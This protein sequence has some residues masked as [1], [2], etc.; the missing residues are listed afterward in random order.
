[1]ENLGPCAFESEPGYINAFLRGMLFAL[2]TALVPKDDRWYNRLHEETSSSAL[3]PISSGTYDVNHKTLWDPQN[4]SFANFSMKLRTTGVSW[5]YEHLDHDPVGMNEV[6]KRTFNVV[7]GT[8]KTIGCAKINSQLLAFRLKKV[9][10][11]YQK[12]VKEA[13]S[14]IERLLVYLAHA[15]QLSLDHYYDDVN[16]R[17]SHLT[18]LSW[19]KSDQTLP[20]PLLPD[21]SIFDGNCPESVVYRYLE[22]CVN[23]IEGG[24]GPC[25]PKMSQK[26]RLTDLDLSD[27][28]ELD[29]LKEKLKPLVLDK[30][31]ESVVPSYVRTYQSKR[32]KREYSGAILPVAKRLLLLRRS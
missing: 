19:I 23:F 9:M 31:W 26:K 15:R 27:Y 6:K 8:F 11:H 28:P 21:Q 13:N 22:G 3:F 12:L 4:A 7:D 20:F 24:H 14:D 30:K 16:A 17:K 5:N 25:C 32:T 29:A 10:E 18:L 1:V 2:K